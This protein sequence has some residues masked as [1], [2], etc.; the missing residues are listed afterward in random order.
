MISRP[1]PAPALLLLALLCAGPS[2]AQ[3]SS[4]EWNINTLIDLLDIATGRST[5]RSTGPPRHCHTDGIRHPNARPRAGSQPD[6]SIRTCHNHPHGTSHHALHPLRMRLHCHEDETVIGP[7]TYIL[8]RT[9]HRH[10]H[11]PHH[12][13]HPTLH[14]H[15]EPGIRPVHTNTP[16]SSRHTHGTIVWEGTAPTRMQARQRALEEGT[17]ATVAYQDP[18]H[19]NGSVIVT[20]SGRNESGQPCRQYHYTTPGRKQT[21][22]TACRTTGR[23][24]TDL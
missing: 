4:N 24:W 12:A 21:E 8:R 7:D 18:M 22:R 1:F 2:H 10:R 5:G 17:G 20:R 6:E 11:D 14:P 23:I 3:S 13:I 16:H 9:C 19:G 15:S